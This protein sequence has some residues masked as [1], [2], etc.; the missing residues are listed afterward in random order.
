MGDLMLH[1]SK[2]KNWKYLEDML[3]ALLK[4]GLKKN[5]QKNVYFY[6]ELQDMGNAISTKDKKVCIT[7]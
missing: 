7:S 1:N 3:K 2:H 4:S 6:T 5:Y